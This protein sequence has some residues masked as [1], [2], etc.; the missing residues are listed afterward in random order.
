MAFFS[1]R[2]QQV[3]FQRDDLYIL[4]MRL[5]TGKVVMAKGNVFGLSVRE[6][7][8]F[9]F[10]GHWETHPKYGPQ[11]AMD[12]APQAPLG[13]WAGEMCAGMLKSSGVPDLL[14]DELL[15]IFGEELSVALMDRHL[16]QRKTLFTPVEIDHLQASWLRMCGIFE[17]MERLE[18]AK[19]T[20]QAIRRMWAKFDNLSELLMTNP[21]RL[22]EL[23]GVSLEQVDHLAQR[24]AV[25][26]TSPFRIKG[27]V[28]ASL[29][30][31]QLAGHVF[32]PMTDIVPKILGTMETLTSKDISHALVEA[33]RENLLVLDQA[34]KP[35]TLAVYAPWLYS[36]ETISARM[37][38]E[39]L[40]MSPPPKEDP[41][42]PALEELRAT[43]TPKNIPTTPEAWRSQVLAWVGRTWTLSEEQLQGAVMALQEPVCV[44]TGLPGTGKTTLLKVVSK[45]LVDLS[46]QVLLIAPTGIAA[47]RMSIVTGLPAMTIHRAFGAKSK[48]HLQEE[49]AA[50]YGGTFF[51]EDEDMGEEDLGEWAYSPSHPHS[52]DVV[53][54]D[55]ASMV[56]AHLLY[57]ILVSTKPSCRLVFIG[58]VDQLPSVGPG[59]VL[60]NLIQSKLFP[61]VSLREVFRQHDQSGI[62]RASHAIV[63]GEVPDLEEVGK[64]FVFVPLDSEDDVLDALLQIV[65][66]LFKKKA[67]F[68]VLSPRHGGTLGVS[69]L[70]ESLRS[71]LNPKQASLAEI[72]VGNRYLRQGDRIMITKNDYTLEAYNGDVGKISS[73]QRSGSHPFVELKLYGSAISSLAVPM[74]KVNLLRLA[75][76]MTVH[77]SQGQE[78]ENILIP[79]VRGFS[80]QL[81]RNLLY[82]AI[83]RAKKK[84][85]LIGHFAAL[86][87]AVQMAHDQVRH[88]LLIERMCGDGNSKR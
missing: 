2:V 5:D 25:P 76:A 31:G 67:E 85:Y 50:G 35:G 30:Q 53:F 68:Q 49:A 24:F 9:G 66:A 27:L 23:P 18:S 48:S 43:P 10:D 1:G 7:V 40:H 73:I 15:N 28:L 87:R 39:R 4:E 26:L 17:T 61:V 71:L 82:T 78:Y 42:D 38:L 80:Q 6:G 57:R 60:S 75:Y 37:L 8:W 58:D 69:N 74:D 34:T 55:E 14:V 16:L 22:L 51:D 21:W 47:K 44:V 88:T 36:V 46:V 32:L 45:M 56:D 64:D 13:K 72:K 41:V 79:W 65:A 77:K 20:R 3:K 83:T 29:R 59:Q 11:L 63:R 81:V 62:I 84:V 54:I 12:R 70:N 86:Q 33:Q 19:F 52:A